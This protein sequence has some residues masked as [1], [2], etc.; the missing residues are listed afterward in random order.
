MAKV[1]LRMDAIEMVMTNSQNKKNEKRGFT[2]ADNRRRRRDSRAVSAWPNPG[3]GNHTRSNEPVPD[4]QDEDRANGSTDKAR[5]LVSAIPADRL[6]EP[7]SQE[8]AGNAEY[9]GQDESSRRVRAR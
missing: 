8:C 6:A 3:S 5:A 7:G 1:K 4:E 9:G 2:L